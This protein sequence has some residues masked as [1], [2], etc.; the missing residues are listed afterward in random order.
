[1]VNIKDATAFGAVVVKLLPLLFNN[2]DTWFQQIE[3]QTE[4]LCERLLLTV[5]T[6]LILPSFFHSLKFLLLF[7][8]WYVWPF[9]Y[10]CFSCKVIPL[11]HSLICIFEISKAVCKSHRLPNK[12]NHLYYSDSILLVHEKFFDNHFSLPCPAPCHA[13]DKYFL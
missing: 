13:F 12:L 4:H 11:V 10:L 3:A 9:V 2:A 1:M 8:S 7:V 5:E 6:L